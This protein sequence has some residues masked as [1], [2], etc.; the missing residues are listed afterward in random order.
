M[1]HDVIHGA[2]RLLDELE[3]E[4][5]IAASRAARP[6]LSFHGADANLGGFHAEALL[7]L[8]HQHVQALLQFPAVRPVD[9]A[10]DFRGIAGIAG[11]D[12]EARFLGRFRCAFGL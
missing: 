5:D 7:P 1:Q 3:V 9:V 10:L 12:D 6:P 4:N 11:V 8:R 2:G